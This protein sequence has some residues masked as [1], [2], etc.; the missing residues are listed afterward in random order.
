MTWFVRATGHELSPEIAICG[1]F[2]Y[3]RLRGSSGAGV[4][5]RRPPAGRAR[6]ASLPESR[7]GRDDHGMAAQFARV[8]PQTFGPR[9][10]HDERDRNGGG[11]GDPRCAECEALRHSRARAG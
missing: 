5:L 10:E 11:P 4:S 1:H 8:A 2:S 9:L 6:D 7:T 3:L